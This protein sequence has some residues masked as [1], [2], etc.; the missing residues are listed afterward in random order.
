[1][2]D[3]DT[4]LTYDISNIKDFEF[5]MKKERYEYFFKDPTYKE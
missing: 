2:L 4:T 3:D 5:A 1:M